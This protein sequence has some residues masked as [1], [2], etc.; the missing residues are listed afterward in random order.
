[1]TEVERFDPYDP[2][3]LDALASGEA[4]GVLVE[5]SAAAAFSAREFVDALPP[6]FPNFQV[7]HGR[8][9]T[10]DGGGLLLFVVDCD[11]PRGQVFDRVYRI[12][13]VPPMALALLASRIRNP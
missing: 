10:V 11:E 7:R 9:V 12:G 2:M 13:Y 3:V 4:I 5:S 6:G 8:K 1:M